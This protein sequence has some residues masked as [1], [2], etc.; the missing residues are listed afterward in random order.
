MH[1]IDDQVRHDLDALLRAVRD[2]PGRL[3]LA[4]IVAVANAPVTVEIDRRRSD[5][6]VYVA[7]RPGATFEGLTG[8]EREVAVLLVS[9]LSN[10]QIARALFISLATVKDHVHSILAKTGCD[11]RSAVAAAWYAPSA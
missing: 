10:A 7:P 2:R 8:R 1:P 9:G 5:A 6:V 3:P 4:E 11:S